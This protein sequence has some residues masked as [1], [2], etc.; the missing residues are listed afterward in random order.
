MQRAGNSTGGMDDKPDYVPGK[1][2]N[3]DIPLSPTASVNVQ[4]K[5]TPGSPV[6][7]TSWVMYDADDNQVAN[8]GINHSVV[9]NGDMLAGTFASGDLGKIFKI[10]ISAMNGTTEI[11]QRGFTFSPAVANGSNEIK[12]IHPLPGAVVTSR[13]GPRRPPTSGGCTARRDPQ[14]N[15]LTRG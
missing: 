9:L 7:A 1:I 6:A 13:F 3:N 11:D 4:F 14:T 12:L 5:L 15:R 8:L 10:K 2:L